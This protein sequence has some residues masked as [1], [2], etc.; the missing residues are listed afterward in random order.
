MPLEKSEDMVKN[1]TTGINQFCHCQLTG[2][3]IG[4]GRLLCD[5][6]ACHIAVFQGRLISTNDRNSTELV[7][8]LEKW[9]SSNP[10]VT[11]QGEQLQVVSSETQPNLNCDEQEKSNVPS[12]TLGSVVAVILV[13][14]CIIT[15]TV[16]GVIYWK[17][18]LI[19]KCSG[20][21]IPNS[22]PF[23]F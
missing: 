14:L 18:R 20:Y 10:T 23:L 12:A 1:I 8:D 2:N 17:W 15:A 3:Y 5:Q 7:E 9:V 11:V 6:E 13:L 22:F 21:D 16:V 4:D 19:K